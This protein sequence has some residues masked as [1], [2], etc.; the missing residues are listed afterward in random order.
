MRIRP[1]E[2]KLCVDET[3]AWLHK[4]WELTE[5]ERPLQPDP[6]YER[7]DGLTPNVV[8][9]VIGDLERIF[10]TEIE[11]YP[12]YHRNAQGISNAEYL[13]PP[14]FNWLPYPQQ[15]AI[16]QG[17]DRIFNSHRMSDEESEAAEEEEDEEVILARAWVALHPDAY[18]E[19]NAD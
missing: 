9:A 10:A 8:R 2:E 11:K 5:Q 16:V 4:V 15:L 17:I 12:G 19:D 3:M 6:F 13:V 7:N 18:F 1:S 14:G